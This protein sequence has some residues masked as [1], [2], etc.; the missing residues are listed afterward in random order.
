MTGAHDGH[1][2]TDH[3]TGVA[4]CLDCDVVFYLSTGAQLC[5]RCS[6]SPVTEQTARGPRCDVCARQEA[7]PPQTIGRLT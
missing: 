6:Q 5:P 1:V 7:R 4:S 2:V 3:G